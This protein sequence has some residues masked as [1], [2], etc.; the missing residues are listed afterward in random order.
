MGLRVWGFGCGVCGSGFKVEEV[1]LT[2]PE[3]CRAAA[4]L[5]PSSG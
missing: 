5:F 2:D 1:N 4:K 3:P